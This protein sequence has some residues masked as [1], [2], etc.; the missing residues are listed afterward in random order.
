MR[1]A[2]ITA[3]IISV[4]QAVPVQAASLTNRDFLKLSEAQRHWW[5]AGVYSMLGHVM[6]YENDKQKADCVFRWFFD[7][8]E[9]R[10][11]QLVTSFEQYPDHAP[12]SIVMSLLRRDCGA[13]PKK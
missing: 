10:K 6:I 11:K 12:T 5:Y 9:R 3:L 8:P 1:L 13:F 4:L 7:G 2:M